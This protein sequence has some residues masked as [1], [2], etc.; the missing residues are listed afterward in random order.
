MVYQQ[1]R[2]NGSGGAYGQ[3]QPY[4][5]MQ[6]GM[7]PPKPP[8]TKIEGFPLMHF[9]GYIS[10]VTTDPPKSEYEQPVITFYIL[11]PYLGASNAPN[12]LS[13]PEDY[14][15]VTNP[16]NVKLKA[17]N[18]EI[19]K[20]K[21][22][23]KIVQGRRPYALI[24]AV[25]PDCWMNQGNKY[26]MWKGHLIWIGDSFDDPDARRALDLPGMGHPPQSS[27]PGAS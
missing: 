7:A 16:Y 8:T 21:S 19:L 4:Q 5:Q 25:Q 18:P 23:L 12:S 14:G 10:L 9:S 11:T 26:P 17:V 15:D 6:F 1:Y 24:A 22:G 27:Q 13:L 2:Q 20:P 3:Q